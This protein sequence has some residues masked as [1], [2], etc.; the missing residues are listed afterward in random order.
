V[1]LQAYTT[2][3]R[4]YFFFRTKLMVEAKQ[5]VKLAWREG[6]NMSICPCKV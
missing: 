5:E 2:K 3:P 1:G 6:N 4:Q